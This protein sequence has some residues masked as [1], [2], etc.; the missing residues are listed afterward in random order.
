M[1]TAFRVRAPDVGFRLLVCCAAMRWLRNRLK[2]QWFRSGSPNSV[3]AVT[4]ADRAVSG[5]N[6]AAA[7]PGRGHGEP[8]LARRSAV[9]HRPHQRQARMFT[10]QPPDDLDP[11]T[12]RSWG[13]GVNANSDIPDWTVGSR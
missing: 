8:A 10:R 2:P 5:V 1:E 9:E 6:R 3:G 4:L 13:S 11:A 7:L 12:S